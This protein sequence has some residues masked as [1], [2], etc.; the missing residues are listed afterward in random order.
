MFKPA[1][2]ARMEEDKLAMA[3]GNAMA[4]RTQKVAELDRLLLQRRR[5]GDLGDAWGL[6]GGHLSGSYRWYKGP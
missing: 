1:P 2:T 6:S 3:A 4:R 5:E